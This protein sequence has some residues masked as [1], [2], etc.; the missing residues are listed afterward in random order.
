[1]KL[2]LSMS[3]FLNTTLVMSNS[4]NYIIILYSLCSLQ[5][6]FHIE[7]PNNCS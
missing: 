3:D 7:Q 4:K 5:Q 1:M 6:S 2:R